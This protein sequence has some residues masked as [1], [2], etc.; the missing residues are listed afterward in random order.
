MKSPVNMFAMQGY[1][2]KKFFL[3]SMPM[4]LKSLTYAQDVSVQDLQS[5]LVNFLYQDFFGQSS[6]YKEGF[7]LHSGSEANEI[8]LFLA[9][10]KNHK[11][12]KLVVTT[13]LSHS[14]IQNACTKLDLETI[15]LD[16]SPDNFQAD[17]GKLKNIL[18]QRGTEILALNIT[19]GTTQLGI[20]EDVILD[21][22]I[23][24]LVKEHNIWLHID[25]AYGGYILNL[26]N[27]PK[28]SEWK[29][30]FEIADSISVDPHKFAGTWG[31]GVLLIKD[32]EN[33]KMV[34]SEI[35]YYAGIG[36]ALGTTRSAFPATTA[37]NIIEKLGLTGLK[38]LSDKC[39]KKAEYITTALNKEGI[40][41]IVKTQSP[42]IPIKIKSEEMALK[43][44]KELK[45][46]NFLISQIKITSK[47]YKIFGL[48][49]CITPR[50]DVSWNNVRLFTQKF[51]SVYKKNNLM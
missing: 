28:K 45:E 43:I 15:I 35:D 47:N 50:P 32:G 25:A 21:N 34:G 39:Y 16:V 26:N 31:C 17:V 8:A 38:K 3:A 18:E 29:H 22:S 48:R 27:H 12:R 30:I 13:N 19:Y 20:T 24:E 37:L 44:E 49:V 46:N 2:P 6:E 4:A 40:D 1:C 14:S 42:N 9:K 23:Q 10:Q 5:N 41:F 33:K 36:T 7:V 11:K 51:I